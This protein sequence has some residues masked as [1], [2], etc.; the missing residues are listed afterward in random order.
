MTNTVAEK[1]EFIL[2]L[3]QRGTS[4][5]WETRSDIMEASDCCHLSVGRG[6]GGRI[7]DNSSFALVQLPLSLI[8]CPVF[9]PDPK[10]E[11]P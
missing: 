11:N 3:S 8:L 7:E 4:F 9:S 5:I 1:N 2:F 6:G 10:Q